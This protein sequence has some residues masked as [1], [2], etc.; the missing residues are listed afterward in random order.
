M[1]K[2]RRNGPSRPGAS[3]GSTLFKAAIPLFVVVL[4]LL[5]G[6]SS[7]ITSISLP[8]GTSSD[9]VDDP[10]AVIGIEETHTGTGT[11]R[12]LSTFTNEFQNPTT[13]SVT[14][15]GNSPDRASLF[16]DGTPQGDSATLNSVLS[17][18]NKTVEAAVRCN[19]SYVG[20]TL[21]YEVDTSS[22]S[23]SGSIKDRSVSIQRYCITWYDSG[24]WDSGNSDQ[25]TVHDNFGDH[26]SEDIEPGYSTS[27]SGLVAYWPFDEDSGTTATEVVGGHDGSLTGLP[28]IGS[29]G[30]LGTTA[31]EF[32]G[33]GDYVTVPE[34]PALE[35][36]NTN[37]VTVSMWVRKEAVQSGWIALLQHSDQSYNLQFESGNTPAFTIYDGGWNTAN[38]GINVNTNQ[39]YH[40][41]GTFDGS[42][43]RIYVD[44][45]QEGTATANYIADASGFDIGIGENLDATGRHFN[46]TIDEVRVYDRALSASEIE[47]L[48]EGSSPDDPTVE[49]NGTHVTDWET[50]DSTLAANDLTLFD[51]VAD[52]SGGEVTVRV[53]SDT[54]GD[55][56]PDE[57]SDP[58]YL[59]GSTGPYSVPGLTTDNDRF[60]LNVELNTSSITAAPCF[61]GASLSPGDGLSVETRSGC[62]STNVTQNEDPTAAFTKDSAPWY[63]DSWTY[64]K[65]IT[66][67]HSKVTSDLSNYPMLVDVSDTALAAKAQDDGDDIVFT[68]GDGTTQLDHEIESFNGSSG[69]ISTWVKVPQVNASAPDTTIYL[70]YNNS[71][72]GN[73]EN[74]AGVWTN[75]YQS[76]WHLNESP[77]DGVANHE[78]STSTD[79]TGSPENFEDGGS[80]STDAAGQIDGA[81]DFAGDD[82]YVSTTNELATLRS[83][84]TFSV[85]VKTTQT[86]DNTMWQAPGL[87]G[88][89]ESG[90]GDDVFW[91]WINAS[92]HIGV[93]AANTP[94]AMSTTPINDDSWH[95]VTLTRD[96][97]SGEVEVYVD[98]ELEATA[99]SATGDITNTF[100]S[101]G[102][103][104]DTG[105][106]PEYFDGVLDEPRIS[107]SV[108][109][110]GWIET[111]FNN[112]NDPSSFHTVGP[113]ETNST[114]VFDGSGS[115][116]PDGSVVTYKWDFESDGT[117]DEVSGSPTT[118]HNFDPGVYDVTL[119]VIDDDSGSDST[120]KSYTIG[121]PPP[122]PS[123]TSSQW[124]ERKA[125]T[126]DHNAI[127]ADLTNFPAMVRLS[128]S[129]LSSAQMDGDDIRFTKG[130]GT[131]K[132]AHEI[133]S[134]DQSTGDLTAW[135]KVP[136]INSTA[137]NTTIYLYYNNSAA[138]N[139]ENVSGVWT[140]G[141]EA[142]WHLDET[143]ST[144]VDSTGNGHNG[145]INA[146][147]TT[148]VDGM[149]GSAIDVGA[150][151]DGWVSVPHDQSLDFGGSESYSVNVWANL[152]T[153]GSTQWILSKGGADTNW[154]LETRDL[155]GDPAAELAHEREAADG[156]DI[157]ADE[158]SDP[159][160]DTWYHL[161]GT[162]DPS[163]DTM[164]YFQNGTSRSTE[165]FPPG[166]TSVGTNT[167]DVGI[168]RNSADFGEYTDGTIDEARISNVQR[169]DAW[170]QAVY[171][172]MANPTGFYT[173]G[174]TENSTIVSFN[175]SASSDPDGSIT[176]YEWD[177]TADGTYD[178][179]GPT[180][181][182]RYPSS[183]NF[184][185]KLRVTDDQGK[186]NTTTVTVSV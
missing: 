18:Q 11:R 171:E 64:R 101:L 145:T 27:D 125:I 81:D 33:S 168:G 158:P 97:P 2:R 108:R 179:T 1:K 87:S 94:G 55:N 151:S 104:E 149:A 161:V 32:D 5:A 59:N 54:N 122:N 155:D 84:A 47:Q 181:T 183:G 156:A 51:V 165:T 44:G 131:T 67:D 37:A 100:S 13:I 56:L 28:T 109:S 15:T 106:S 42:D 150:T 20:G 133:E 146:G 46:G 8:R 73:Q 61:S 184:D 25:G 40:I 115:S 114:F 110:A 79:N 80:G 91:G 76:V 152:D 163:S 112:T 162:Y 53:Q 4:V 35:M 159:S 105:G 43:I 22:S 10:S 78:D 157:R 66:I 7:L 107:G 126:F 147:V 120:T 23:V 180:V 124:D 121:N 69:S 139:Q 134:F 52:V 113:E 135:V 3:S 16:V 57:T 93:M 144:A 169:S 75:G 68:A 103:I 182:H 31:Y 136:N 172:N 119:Q 173:V 141:Y 19:D 9:V 166:G 175:A 102:R 24:D 164:E 176:S 138:D 130:D 34:A 82:D 17:G 83:T 58:I 65:S 185:V 174:S 85:W 177:F 99:T 167:E 117:Y 63:N 26:D 160:V 154:A 111:T 41:A 186:T 12:T 170:V 129:D 49:W 62:G 29:T 71:G 72:V 30:I 36:N 38:S 74:P 143:G 6:P 89:E 142:V 95:Y 132:L 148:G 77:G 48:A 98:G 45:V 92:G 50:T 127:G 88:I 116:D 39:W 96:S 137:P 118:T 14:L 90:G 153:V 21:N 70:Y 128:D 60:R 140:N 178:A 86:G 123:F